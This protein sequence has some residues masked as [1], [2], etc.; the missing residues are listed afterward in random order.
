MPPQV[1]VEKLREAYVKDLTNA[2]KYAQQKYAGQTIYAFTLFGYGEPARL[3][4]NVLTEESLKQ[5]SQ[6]KFDND[7][8]DTLEEVCNTFRYSIGDSRLFGEMDGLTPT[9]DKLFDPVAM[10]MG[11][12]AGYRALCTAAIQAFQELD[13]AGVFGRGAE[14]EKLILLIET[15]EV[16]INRSNTSVT[17]INPPPVAERYLQS[18]PRGGLFASCDTLLYSTDWQTLFAVGSTE[19]PAPETRE[20]K[21]SVNQLAAYETSGRKFTQRWAFQ[22]PDWGDSIRTIAESPNDQSIVALRNQVNDKGETTLLMRFTAHSNCPVNEKSFPGGAAQLAISP[23]GAQIAVSLFDQTLLICDRDF[24]LIWKTKLPH[25]AHGLLFLESGPLLAGGTEQI[26]KIDLHKREAVSKI[27]CPGFFLS[28][29]REQNYLAA[30]R[31]GY[32]EIERAADPY[33]F[34]VLKLPSFKVHREFKSPDKRYFNP[35]LSRD[36]KLVAVQVG[37]LGKERSPITV[38][39]LASGESVFQ[40]RYK[41]AHD[42]VFDPNEPA[43]V[44]AQSV[45]GELPIDRRPFNR[46]NASA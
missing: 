22:F 44:I 26:V 37:T 36:G 45:Y 39:D 13:R 21:E 35:V 30:G 27:A 5:Y 3:S 11:D 9:V 38:F 7:Y 32:D 31:Y 29:D 33:G 24:N 16:D 10:Q 12:E 4:P 23:D 1:T 28:T 8:A 25:R 2:W 14:R 42:W 34:Y 41:L 40:V 19:I 43:L 18:L 6:E 20:K 46:S 15:D 17:E